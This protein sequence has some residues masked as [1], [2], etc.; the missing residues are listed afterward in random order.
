MKTVKKY[1]AQGD[2]VFLRVEK[3]PD[4][5]VKNRDQSLVIAH[6]ETGHHHVATGG[7]HYLLKDDPMVAYLAI[8]NPVKIEH[9]RPF[10]THEPL[11]LYAKKEGETIWEIRRQRE[12]VPE[13]WR[14]VE[15]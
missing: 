10:D 13:G 14:Q 6:S 2:V 4:D 8:T 3:L 7:E 15:D 9:K 1:A 5:A 11:E 12:Y